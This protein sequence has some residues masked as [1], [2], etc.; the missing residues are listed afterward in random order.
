MSEACKKFQDQIAGYIDHEIEP[1][2]TEMVSRHL[3]QCSA[4]AEETARQQ[5]IKKQVADHLPRAITPPYLRAQIRRTLDRYGH[6]Q[7]LW[8]EL[9]QLIRWHPIPAFAIVIALLVMPTLVTY[10]MVRQPG[11]GQI[12]QPALIAGS[13]EGEMIC[14][15]CALLQALSTPFAHDSTHRIGLRCNDGKIWNILRSPKGQE[16]IQATTTLPQ[17]VRVE[18]H[19]FRNSYYVEVKT[20][21]LI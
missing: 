7:N 5:R 19:L 8:S 14:V 3:H 4:C 11:S 20:F 13:L 16:L 17:R 1:N 10:Y 9:R 6:G 18:G 15:D 21:N 12:S 2:Q